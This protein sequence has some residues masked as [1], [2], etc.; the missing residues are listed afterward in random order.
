[1]DKVCLLQIPAM[2][3]N[4]IVFRCL[5]NALTVIKFLIFLLCKYLHKFINNDNTA[6]HLT[7]FCC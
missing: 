7:S 3:N 1:M 4:Y 2:L 6:A 5:L